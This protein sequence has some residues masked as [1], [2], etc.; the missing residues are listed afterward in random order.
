MLEAACFTTDSVVALSSDISLGLFNIFAPYSR[1]ILEIVMLSVD[2]YTSSTNLEFKAASIDQAS[3]GFPQKSKI[4]L[5]GNPLLPPLAGIRAIF[6][7]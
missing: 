1:A 5:F 6:N 3:N 4:F 7:F 2:T